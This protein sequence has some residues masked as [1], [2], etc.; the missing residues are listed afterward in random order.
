MRIKRSVLAVLSVTDCGVLA[1]VGQDA[2]Q[3]C[4]LGE[5]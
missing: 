5:T 3:V 2:V 1:R 4:D